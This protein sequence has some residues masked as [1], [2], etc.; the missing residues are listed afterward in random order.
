MQPVN[1]NVIAAK[2]TKNPETPK[3]CFAVCEKHTNAEKKNK[4]KRNFLVIR[5]AE[6]VFYHVL[7]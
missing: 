1:I 6:N 5:K 7:H 2:V 4:T 3:K